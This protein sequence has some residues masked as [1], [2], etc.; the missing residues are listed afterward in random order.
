MIKQKQKNCAHNRQPASEID[1]RHNYS[2]ILKS[3]KECLGNTFNDLSVTSDV[4]GQVKVKMFDIS[5]E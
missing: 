1:I 5:A 2:G 3:L 4:T